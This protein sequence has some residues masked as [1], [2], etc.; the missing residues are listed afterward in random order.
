MAQSFDNTFDAVLPSFTALYKFN[1]N[2]S[3][4]AQ[5]AEGFLA[6]NENFFNFNNPSTTSLSPEQSWNYQIGT[7]WQTKQ[8][9]ASVDA[10]YID[11]SNFIGSQTVQGITTFFNQ[12]GAVYKGLEAEATY[13][14]GYGV[15]LYANGSINSAKD[16]QTG[17]WLQNAP[18]STGALGVIYDKDG[19]YGSLIE[20][21]VGS[22]YGDTAQ[23]VG[24]DPYGTLDMALGYT[25][26]S[27]MAGVGQDLDQAPAR[28]SARHD[29]DLRLGG[30]Y[31]GGKYAAVLDR[32]GPQRF[33]DDIDGVLTT[34]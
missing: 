16:K 9:A 24:L 33:R 11:F 12:G 2:W 4:Y 27:P 19:I 23:Q 21:W 22:R 8:L 15:S 34:I 20:K 31:G 3:A 32:P 14:I 28:Q 6:P 1:D 5:A 29:E 25:I 10:Y 26:D 30:Q 7:S 18:N 17:L 13:S